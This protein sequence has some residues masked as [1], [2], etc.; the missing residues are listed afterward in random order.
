MTNFNKLNTYFSFS[1]ELLLRPNS[2]LSKNPLFML[3]FYDVAH[4]CALRPNWPRK[5]CC[6]WPAR[7]SPG[8]W[9]TWLPKAGMTTYAYLERE[10]VSVT[11]CNFLFQQVI[12]L[13]WLLFNWRS[14]MVSNNMYVDWH[15]PPLK[16]ATSFVVKKVVV[17][18]KKW[19]RD[20]I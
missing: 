11:A 1:I 3:T 14:T 16:E 20:I 18:M 17:C 4:C 13:Y 15:C 6:D 10:S 5:C 12:R 2:L 19:L 8:L 7:P 9:P